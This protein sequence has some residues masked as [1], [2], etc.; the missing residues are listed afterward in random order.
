MVAVAIPLFAA[1]LGVTALLSAVIAYRKAAAEPPTPGPAPVPAPEPAP[2]PTPTPGPTPG[3]TPFPDQTW[4]NLHGV[5]VERGITVS[6]ATQFIALAAQKRWNAFRLNVYWDEYEAN[7]TAYEN[8]LKAILT[9]A[10]KYN[11][12]VII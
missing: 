4:V 7:P 9:E 10:K 6:N 1:L 3:P 5:N 12:K 2:E 11:I 8:R